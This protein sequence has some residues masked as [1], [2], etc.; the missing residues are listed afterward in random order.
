MIFAV[1]G[2][3]HPLYFLNKKEETEWEERAVAIMAVLADEDKVLSQFTLQYSTFEYWNQSISSLL[4]P[5]TPIRPE[6]ELAIYPAA[7][8]LFCSAPPLA[9]NLR[10][11]LKASRHPIRVFHKLKAA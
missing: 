4:N 7:W 6:I 5:F 11:T 9:A 2:I 10:T 3:C 1:F 8:L